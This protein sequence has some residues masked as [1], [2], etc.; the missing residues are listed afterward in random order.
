MK[1]NLNR[2]IIGI[3][4]LNIIFYLLVNKI[5]LIVENNQF[6]LINKIL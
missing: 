3:I 1:T 4:N 2:L 5:K 6:L